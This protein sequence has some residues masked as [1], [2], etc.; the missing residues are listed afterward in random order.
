MCEAYPFIA[1]SIALSS[2]SQ[3]RWC[4]P[5]EP[6]P[7]MYIPGRLRT[8]SRPS[9]TVMSLAVYVELAMLVAAPPGLY[10]LCGFDGADL[11]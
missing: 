11:A 7:P 1:S 9:R 3:T 5:A 6:T 8:G 2:V 4:S 10:Q